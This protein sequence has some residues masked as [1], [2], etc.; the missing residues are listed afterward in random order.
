MFID[1]SEWVMVPNVYGMGT[2]AVVFINRK[3]TC[4]NNWSNI[5]AGFTTLLRQ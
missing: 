2:Y 5:D 3:S 4:S 1:S